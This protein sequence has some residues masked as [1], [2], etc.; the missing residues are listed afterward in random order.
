MAN[1]LRDGDDKEL[2]ELH[3]IATGGVQRVGFRA[4]TR[5]HA[6]SLGLTGTVRNLANGSVEI[7]AQGERELLHHLLVRLRHE[8]GELVS[9]I[10]S[11]YTAPG[12]RFQSFRI[13]R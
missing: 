2:L 13:L 12:E 9:A 6:K 7:Y 5:Y 1:Q 4:T 10:D 11:T 3:A 8:F